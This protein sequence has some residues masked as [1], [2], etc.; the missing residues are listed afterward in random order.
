MISNVIRCPAFSQRTF[1]LDTLLSS[2]IVLIQEIVATFKKRHHPCQHNV[3]CKIAFIWWEEKINKGT[4]VGVL[5]NV[6]G[7]SMVQWMQVI[8]IFVQNYTS[9]F[10]QVY[11]SVILLLYCYIIYKK[12]AKNWKGYICIYI[13][14][15]YMSCFQDKLERFLAYWREIL[16]CFFVEF[17]DYFH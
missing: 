17:C 12:L 15:D 3:K 10:S 5:L 16:C 8:Q 4:R 11:W 7:W 13:E 14:R 2:K 1:T 6:K 9:L